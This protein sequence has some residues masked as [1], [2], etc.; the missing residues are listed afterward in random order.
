MLIWFICWGNLNLNFILIWLT[1]VI[2]HINYGAHVFAAHSQRRITRE[3][4][5]VWDEP[6]QLDHKT[7][8]INFEMLKPTKIYSCSSFHIDPK[9]RI[10]KSRLFSFHFM[11]KNWIHLSKITKKKKLLAKIRSE[12]KR[13]GIKSFLVSS[14][15]VHSLPLNSF[16]VQASNSIECSVVHTV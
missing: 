5:Y 4:I 11:P 6:L 16:S 3:N 10:K 8:W 12:I 9:W 7:G 13:T 2:L 1:V 14:T 15:H